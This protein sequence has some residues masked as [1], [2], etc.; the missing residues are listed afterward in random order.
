M[1][2][3]KLITNSILI[4][5]ITL[6]ALTESA[7]ARS[8]KKYSS[9]NGDGSSVSF[10][11]VLVDELPNGIPNRPIKTGDNTV[12]FEKA[13][14]DFI[15]PSFY[16]NTIKYTNPVVFNPNGLPVDLA[17]CRSE[18]ITYENGIY[19][20]A[21]GNQIDFEFKFDAQGKV[22]SPSCAETIEQFIRVRNADLKVQLI[23]NDPNSPDG[24]QIKY[25][26]VKKTKNIE[27]VNDIGILNLTSDVD[28]D[29]AIN[30]FSYI[31]ETN[32]LRRI[33]E[34]Q[35]RSENQ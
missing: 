16:F 21:S 7:T 28:R 14:Q 29:K 33:P 24:V 5:G 22:T 11:F 17:A 18:G 9:S 34:I 8:T 3:T 25:S 20:D 35:V 23:K 31:I 27:V 26:I 4:T 1:N 6:M 10:T 2:I 15:R 13:I 12:V 30:N 32:L 19:K